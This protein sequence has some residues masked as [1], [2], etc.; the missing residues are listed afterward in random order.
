MNSVFPNFFI[1]T[2]FHVFAAGV[3]AP[4]ARYVPQYTASLA[5]WRNCS[6]LASKVA[7]KGVVVQTSFLGFDNTQILAELAMYPETLRGVAVL[8]STTDAATIAVLHSYGVRGIRLNL[9]GRSHDVADWSKPNT[10][11]LWEAIESWGWHVELHTDQGALPAVLTQMP[12]YVPLVIDHMGKP[13]HPQAQDATVRALVKRVKHAAV[14]VKLS[15]AYRLGGLDAKAVASVWLEELGAEQLLW[16]S[17]WPCTNH[18]TMADYPKLFG[19]LT[20]WVG[21]DHLDVIL[22]HNPDRLYFKP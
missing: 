4:D 20:D 13:E 7:A 10:H 6:E 14:H 5:A 16:G 17:D 19:V 22:R 8:P 18:E 1:D 2:H 12:A 21:T 15:G 11:G 9:A 3:G